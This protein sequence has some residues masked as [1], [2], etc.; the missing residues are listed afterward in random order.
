MWLNYINYIYIYIYFTFIY[1]Y[2]YF[3][4]IYIYIY[5]TFIYII[6]YL[7]IQLHLYLIP[8]CIDS[9]NCSVHLHFPLGLLCEGLPV[10]ARASWHRLMR[11]NSSCPFPTSHSVMT[12]W[13]QEIGHD[14]SI[15]TTEIGRHY[16]SQYFSSQRTGLQDNIWTWSKSGMLSHWHDTVTFKQLNPIVLSNMVSFF[17]QQI[18]CTSFY[19]IFSRYGE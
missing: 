11:A 7:D 10:P 12:C 17:L 13:Q 14:G 1:I 2:I 18:K 3:T 8:L 19:S 16:K 4:F 9:I 6:I 5:F 15:C